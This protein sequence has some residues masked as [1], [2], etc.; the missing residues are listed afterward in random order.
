MKIFNQGIPGLHKA[1]GQQGKPIKVQSSGA[2]RKKDDLKLSSEGRLWGMA[3]NALRELP[4]PEPRADLAELKEAVST[5]TYQIN[6]NEVAEEIWQE[7][8]FDS[9][10]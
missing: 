9:K 3:A 1:Y 7:N 2:P 4:E 10:A 8:V 6:C 5:G